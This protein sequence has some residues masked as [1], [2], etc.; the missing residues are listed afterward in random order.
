M[1]DDGRGVIED[2]VE[3]VRWYRLASEQGHA[4]AQFLLAITYAEGDGVLKDPLLAHMW[5]NIASANGDDTARESRDALE[6]DMSRAEVSRATDL[7]RECT[8]RD[9]RTAN[10][11]HTLLDGC[12]RV[13]GRTTR[14][15]SPE[16][17][18]RDLDRYLHVL[19]L[20]C[21]HHVYGLNGRSA[22]PA[23]RE[24]FGRN[25]LPPVVPIADKAV[26]KQV[27]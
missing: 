23:S 27:A 21:G 22:A 4:V 11:R 26:P 3:A 24:A 6:R 12:F 9:T 18:Q 7:A 14:Y 25:T 2:D 1:Y 10:R 15:T 13:K 16:E 5:F 17:F 19:S 20:T 8:P